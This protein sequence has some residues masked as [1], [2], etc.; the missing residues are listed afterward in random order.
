M[1][2][3]AEV[4]AELK[5]WEEVKRVGK[6]EV[7]ESAAAVDWG[8]QDG[9]LAR[10]YVWGG[11]GG[12]GEGGGSGGGEGGGGEGGGEGGGNGGGGLGSGEGDVGEGGW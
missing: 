11:E 7:E 6:K 9:R 1:G 10:V 12:G 5:V 4:V 3:K 2:V 8:Q